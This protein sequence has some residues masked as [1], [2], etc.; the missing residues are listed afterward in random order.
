MHVIPVCF[1]ISAWVDV[2]IRKKLVIYI[3]N[4]NILKKHM[5]IILLILKEIRKTY[6]KIFKRNKNY[7][8]SYHTNND[9]I[10]SF[11]GY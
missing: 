5:I 9:P 6:E 1:F 10:K 2:T 11:D 7:T 8:V 4:I 3:V